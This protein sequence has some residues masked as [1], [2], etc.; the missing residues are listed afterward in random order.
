VTS[1]W[2]IRQLIAWTVPW[3]TDR[4]IESPRLDTEVL[5][6]H[7]LKCQRLDLY[8]NPDAPV[9]EVERDEYKLLI[10]RRAAREPVAY[11]VGHKEFWRRQFFVDRRVLIPRPETETLIETALELVNGN[12][13]SLI[14]DLG[15]GSGCIAI[16]LAAECQDARVIATDVSSA[17]IDVAIL[18]AKDLNVTERM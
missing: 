1:I 6:S 4:G 5:L 18:N 12:P 13:G 16:T 15:T 3:F 8:L 9:T 11:I 10:K 14:A 17:A 7:A 2:T